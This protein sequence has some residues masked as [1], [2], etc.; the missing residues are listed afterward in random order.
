MGALSAAVRLAC[1]LPGVVLR[2][3]RGREQPLTRDHGVAPLPEVAKHLAVALVVIVVSG[4][5][6]SGILTRVGG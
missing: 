1:A 4:A 3:A 2:I 5:I 6:G